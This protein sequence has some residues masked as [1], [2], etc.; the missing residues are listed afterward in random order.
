MIEP[1][2]KRPI[3]AHEGEEFIIVVSGKLELEYGK[4]KYA[5]NAGDSVY[6]NSVVPHAVNSADDKP[7]TIYAVI[8]TPI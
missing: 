1:S 3:S 5:L 6:Y 8:Y 2:E 4:Q 7:A